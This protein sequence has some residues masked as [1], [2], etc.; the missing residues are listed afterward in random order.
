MNHRDQRSWKN[1][2]MKSMIAAAAAYAI[3]IKKV[4]IFVIKITIDVMISIF[5]QVVNEAFIFII[6][7]KSISTNIN[8]S[9][10][11]VLFNDIT[12]YDIKAV[13]F[14]LIIAMYDYSDI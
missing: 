3:F 7:T 12:I 5:N 11:H 10:E 6:S 8:F 4:F 2:F 14:Q 9:F 1:K 13:T